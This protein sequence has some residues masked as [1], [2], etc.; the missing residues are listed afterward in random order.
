MRHSLIVAHWKCRHHIAGPVLARFQS[1]APKYTA[2]VNKFSTK[3]PSDTQ[4]D[5]EVSREDG[6]I[7]D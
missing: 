6:D 1:T 2:K 4:E 7:L 5:Q 3:P